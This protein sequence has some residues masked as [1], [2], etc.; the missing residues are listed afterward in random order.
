[1]DDIAVIG[2]GVRFPGDATSPEALWEI[3]EHGESQWSEI[4][5]D[6]LNVNGYYHPGGDRQGSISFKGGH[7]LKG[8]VA[9]FDAP[10]FSIAAADAKAID[11]QQRMLLEVCYEAL[12]NAGCTKEDI[13]GTDTSVYVGSF[14]KDYEQICLRDPDWQPQYAATGNGIAIM[15]NRIS[16]YFNL[17]GPSMTLDTGCSGSLVSIHLAAQSLRSGESSLAIA[18]GA[19]LI[20][21][22]N[23]IMPMTA[24]NFL[25]PDGKC[26]TFDARAN[27]YGRGEGIG[28]VILKRLSDAIRDND[29]IRAVIRGTQVNQ[30][31]RTT[32]IT[33]PSKEAQV[34]NITAVYKAA[35]L[36]FSD[37]AYVECHGTGTQAG[38]W[39]EL[40]AISET[41]G[42]SR[43]PDSPIFVGSVKPNIGHLEGAAGVAG[44]IKAVLMLERERIPPHIN[45]ETP[46]PAIDFKEW[47]VQV[48]R[49]AQPWPTN[50]KK[51]VSVNCFGFGGTNAHVILD[52]AAEYLSTQQLVAHHSTTYKVNG[53]PLQ[54]GY[55]HSNHEGLVPENWQVFCFSSNERS[56]IQRLVS[57]HA[58]MLND[59]EELASEFLSNYAYTM[60][61]RRSRLEWKTFYVSNSISDLVE[62]MSQSEHPA[63]RSA[64][65][66]S[67]RLC[68][69][70][71]G[72]GSQWARMG[73]DLRSFPVFW[74]SLNSAS[75]Y[76]RTVLGSSFDLIEEISREAPDS[77]LSSAHISQPAT[78][79]IQIAIV[80][81][82]QSLGIRPSSVVGHS[83]GEIAAAFA[84]GSISREEAWEVAYYRG[85]A[86]SASRSKLPGFR[87]GM[88]AVSM[89]LDEATSYISMLPDP[90]EI[91]CINSPSSVTLSGKRE[92]IEHASHDLKAKSIRHRILP[93]DMA[94]HSSYM[95][96]FEGDYVY[97]ISSI[98]P[99]AGRRVVR[100]FSSVSG[101]EVQCS[102]LDASYWGENMVSP[103]RFSSAIESLMAVPEDQCPS[104]F[105]EMGPSTVL[106]TM[107]LE[108]LASRVKPEQFLCALDKR[109][110]G[111]ASVLNIVGE[112]WSSGQNVNLKSAISRRF[113]QPRLKCLSQLTSYPWNHTKSY[114]HES[115]LSLANRFREYGRLDLIGA[116]TADS[117]SYEPR[118]RGFLRISENPWIQDHQVQRTVI[119]PAAGMIT[120]VLEGARQLKA[121]FP[122][123]VGYEIRNMRFEKAV[124]VPNTTHGVEVALNMRA[125]TDAGNQR[126]PR[127]HFTFSIYSK[128][129]EKEWE[130]H[131]TGDLY[132]CSQ[133]QNMEAL[134]EA[135]KNQHDELG[136]V[137]TTT[138]NPRQLYEHLDT[139]GISYGPMFRNILEIS[140]GADRCIS[141]ICVPETRFKMPANFE[142]PHLLHPGTLDS[143]FQTLFALE[144][145]P[146]VPYLVE[147]IFVSDNLDLSTSREFVGHAIAKQRPFN[148]AEAQI[149]MCCTDRPLDQIIIKGL[150]FSGDLLTS[151]TEASFLP[152]Y[153][154]LA[155]ELVW[156]EYS[157]TA[158]FE[159]FRH[160]ISLLCH[161]NPR[162]SILQIGGE[163]SLAKYA[164]LTALEHEG[165]PLRLG[166][167]SFIDQK[168]SDLHIDDIKMAPFRSY[169]DQIPD[170]ASVESEYDLILVHGDTE[171]ELML[172][173]R[174][175]KPS[176]MVF[177]V[178]A[179][180]SDP[181]NPRSN[182]LCSDFDLGWDL[183]GMQVEWCRR[184]GTPSTEETG[185]GRQPT[186]RKVPAQSTERYMSSNVVLV[187]PSEISEEVS[188]FKVQFREHLAAKYP[189][190][191]VCALRLQDAAREGAFQKEALY[192][193]LL[194]ISREAC[195]EGFVF[196]WSEADFTAFHSLQKVAKTIVWIT[197]GAG[198]TATTPR[199]API[200]GLART[201]MSEDLQKVFAT[202]DLSPTS[203]L[204][205]TRILEM[206]VT[207]CRSVTDPA[208]SGEAR[209]V[210]FA[211]NDG[212]LFIPRLKTLD[213]LNYIIEKGGSSDHIVEKCFQ[214][215]E[216]EAGRQIMLESSLHS[217]VLSSRS[218]PS[219]HFKEIDLDELRPGHIALSFE[220]AILAVSNEGVA[221][222][223]IRK[224]HSHDVTGR[225]SAIGA[226]VTR[227][228]I[229]DRV[230]SLIPK[231]N[232]LRT[233]AQ[234]DAALVM[235]HRPGF[236]PSQFLSAYYALFNA[237]KVR[238]IKN[239]LIH[240]GASGFG[241]AAVELALLSG[242]T[243]FTTVTGP[244][245]DTQR[246]LL[247]ERGIKP[248]HIFDGSNDS[249]PSLVKRLTRDR[250]VDLV[251][252]PTHKDVELSVAC[253][254]QCGTI[255]YFANTS[256]D[257]SSISTPGI[258]VTMVGFDLAT[259]L[260][261]DLDHAI[262]MAHLA[263]NLTAH[264][265]LE[266][267]SNSTVEHRFDISQLLDAMKAINEPTHVG[268]VCITAG[269]AQENASLVQVLQHSLPTPLRD[270]I[271]VDATYVLAG[272]LGGLGRSIAELLV[273]NGAK[274][275]AFL[276]RSGASSSAAAQ[277]LEKLFEQGVAAEAFSV[278]IC[279]QVALQD[280]LST[281][282]SATMP[283]IAGVFHCAAVIKDAVFDNMTYESW[284][285]GFKPKALGSC[286]L[287]D[288]VEA[289]G[290]DPFYVFLA[291]SAGVIG[292]RGQANYAAG[293][294][295]LDA[296]A[297]NLRIRGKR[298]T[299]LDLGPIL[300]AGMLAE[301]E[302]ILDIL[303]A[304]GFY[305]IR[306]D[307][308][309]TIVK[310]SITGETSRGIPLPSQVVL[311][312][313]TGGLM[314][315]NQPADP[316]WSR[317][318]MYSYLNIVDMP[319][320]D[321]SAP[322]RS[323]GLGIKAELMSCTDAE[324]ATGI[325]CSG[326][327]S[328]LAKSMNMTAEEID[329]CRPP[330]AY[331]VDSLVAVGIRNWVSRNCGVDVSVFEIMSELTVF[332]L[333]MLVVRNGGF[334]LNADNKS[335]AFSYE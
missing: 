173:R 10:F 174:F 49:I 52:G 285:T 40:K 254:R 106:R 42:K 332:E 32:G 105:V 296:L 219:S 114:W 147:S 192:I 264:V 204:S 231:G 127:G 50:A 244:N 75:W 72:Q 306:H 330:S 191:G 68:F 303:R 165:Q 115:H 288:A 220:S 274:N 64:K 311:G 268:S 91:A 6:R 97:N 35:G 108:T 121:R 327:S 140:K 237:G 132:F 276:S 125:E 214:T 7:F 218:V 144:P 280:L 316:Y 255:V 104:V 257:F 141:K 261:E 228:Q 211:E 44:L 74:N 128:A 234:V 47:N 131:S 259:L 203:L 189:A 116:P 249:Y 27:G 295:F 323:V 8:N 175:L 281:T 221:G 172:A 38:D 328:M 62:Q 304:S 182:V 39:R 4:P 199:C 103:V 238:Q 18:A 158:Q 243:V 76:L 294:A 225:V 273:A 240:A 248:G 87:G 98:S 79:A 71:C 329:P 65:Q 30:D 66:S 151:S 146:R 253:V 137:C 28:V 15:A 229:G 117:V 43:A 197:R 186:M 96:N 17:H 193:S 120:M 85:L 118:W 321:L 267:M 179:A 58:S 216:N 143:M 300:G 171:D 77:V 2:L 333:S 135:F 167:Y 88:V 134:F 148:E 308:F 269:S 200:T 95:K 206:L 331:G 31:G 335:W 20:L 107:V 297:K 194:D 162:L 250:G 13:D 48:S 29:T 202:F 314:L 320:P 81:L 138:V 293:N 307:D 215:D 279:D 283:P 252:N 227:Y 278:D 83:S 14:V 263:N 208:L 195:T 180:E 94:Y 25:S 70:F 217:N 5:K 63:T 16:Y 188:L 183:D 251:Y 142:Y 21:T 315:Q 119:Y 36:S 292:T 129:L 222:Q 100:M 54:N 309:L 176:G 12:E 260:I 201:L 207:V 318:A 241:L 53:L 73:L 89:S 313:G 161:R 3:L 37:T 90:L 258:P 69:L 67:P 9:E 84:C 46:N 334:G 246:G 178:L 235:S 181:K 34:A 223:D 45:F 123:V 78:T 289:L 287:V 282:V 24:L 302:V 305:G 230:V 266:W 22:P 61:C 113:P 299:S 322:T 152:S 156:R 170:F 160:A 198:M 190:T 245:M 111:P 80:D 298:A 247:R 324:S 272:G 164:L 236:V 310:H 271:S 226:G 19:G 205:D 1:M 319:E 168:E 145:V 177:Q 110:P 150:R 55:P 133:S 93:V 286:N 124:V 212:A 187:L 265:C 26:F 157:E 275:I 291:S 56:G 256:N 23:T 169:V 301:D 290:H 326:L 92:V 59:T 209:E 224:W 33:L 233:T 185:E 11:P 159:S 51:R 57:Q 163:L 82:L 262:D 99:A 239:V 270:Y 196:S 213:D 317:T 166:K 136:V 139:V 149:S 112:L 60:G 86:A 130:K 153:R 155:T 242:A 109:R 122:E 284:N 232:G 210:D 184:T 126:L 41:L 102:R 312:V 325:V 277:F 154:N 101:R